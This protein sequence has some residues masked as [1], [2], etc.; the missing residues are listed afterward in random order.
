MLG[1]LCSVSHYVIVNLNAIILSVLKPQLIAYD[2][3]CSAWMLL[4]V[5]KSIHYFSVVLYLCV[6]HDIYGYEYL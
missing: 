5:E 3:H 4:E 6:H 1:A 2:L